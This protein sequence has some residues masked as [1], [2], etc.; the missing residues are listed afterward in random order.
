M[1]QLISTTNLPLSEIAAKLNFADQAHLSR[2][3]KALVGVC[4]MTARKNPHFTEGWN[5]YDFWGLMWGENICFMYFYFS[6]I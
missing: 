2:D 5:L 3:F 1:I 6:G 4:P